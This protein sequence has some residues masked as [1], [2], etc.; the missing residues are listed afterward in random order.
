MNSK[1]GSQC[2]KYKYGNPS[3][4]FKAI[5]AEKKGKVPVRQ[6]DF[7]PNFDQ[8]HYWA[9]Y[10]TTNPMLKVICKDFSRL[11]NL[12]RKIYMKNC[13]NKKLND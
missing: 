8:D 3:D 9:G 10:Y 6:S 4:Y 12:F 5:Q 7:I 13:I 1:S 11:S 2:P